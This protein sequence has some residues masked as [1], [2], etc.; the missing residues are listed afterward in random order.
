VQELV[1]ASAK[2]MERQDWMAASAGW[3]EA[4]RLARKPD[5]RQLVKD[6]EAR[7][8]DAG[9][10]QIE[11]ARQMIRDK[12]YVEA[13]DQYDLISRAFAG[14]WP[15]GQATRILQ[16]AATDPVLKL[17]YQEVRA[18]RLSEELD[19]FIH[20]AQHQEQ[21]AQNP[22]APQTQ[23][24]GTRPFRP[25]PLGG[26]QRVSAMA[27]LDPTQRGRAIDM[28]AR[29]VRECSLS[30]TGKLAQMDL[31]DL[32]QR[33]L[34][35]EVQVQQDRQE[36]RRLLQT[37]HNYRANNRA[38]LAAPIYQQIIRD[39]PDTPEAKE[40]LEAL[41]QPYYPQMQVGPRRVP[42]PVR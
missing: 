25:L 17:P 28:L 4:K 23:P 20:D 19:Q 18:R 27:S 22:P 5:D 15:G 6:L 14:T 10:T 1:D 26:P 40:A 9:K 29:I 32:N 12:A 2:A 35:Q 3:R 8:A 39:Y 37:A 13:L 31:E 16:H 33:G 7:L 38:D 42:G 34:V 30:P 41:R 21:A 11:Q 36:A 24:A